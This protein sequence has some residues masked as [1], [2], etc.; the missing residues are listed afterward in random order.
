MFGRELPKNLDLASACW[1]PILGQ[2]T[3]FGRMRQD[4][5]HCDHRKTQRDQTSPHLT[6]K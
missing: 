3:P 2:R 6:S 4:E 1:F 5:K